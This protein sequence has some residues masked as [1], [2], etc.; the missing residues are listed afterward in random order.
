LV[1]EVSL[2]CFLQHKEKFSIINC[3]P[4]DLLLHLRRYEVSV[5]MN[6]TALLLVVNND[7]AN[8]ESSR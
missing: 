7:L 2:I 1:K 6:G 8:T 3:V 5:R 4:G